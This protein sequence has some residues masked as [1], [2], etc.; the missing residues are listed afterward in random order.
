L[1]GGRID[2]RGEPDKGA[3]FTLEL[4]MPRL[5]PAERRER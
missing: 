4:P 2:A 5:A 3:T 1:M